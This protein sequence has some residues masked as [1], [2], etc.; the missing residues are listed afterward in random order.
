MVRNV[1]TPPSWAINILGLKGKI[2]DYS[3]EGNTS[4]QSS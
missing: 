2:K 4:I 3:Q 1:S